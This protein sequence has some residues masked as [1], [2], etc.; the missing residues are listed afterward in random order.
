MPIDPMISDAM[1]GTFRNM[2]QDYKDSGL[3][4]EDFD[5]M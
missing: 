2:A 5:K 4:G 3:S 1:L